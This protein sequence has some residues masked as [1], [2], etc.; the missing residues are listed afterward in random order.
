MIVYDRESFITLRNNNYPIDDSTRKII[1]TLVVKPCYIN[2]YV[3]HN[4]YSGKRSGSKYFNPKYSNPNNSN[5]WKTQLPKHKS[6][7]IGTPVK[8]QTDKIK[9]NIN[10]LLNKLSKNNLDTISHQV[11]EKI[12]ELDEEIITYI[13]E[14]IL[15]KA[16]V[17]PIYCPYYV[18]I[19]LD[20]IKYNIIFKDTIKQIC[21]HYFTMITYYKEKLKENIQ[22]DNYDN[23]CMILKNKSKKKGFSQLIGELYMNNIIDI[24][25]IHRITTILLCNIKTL[26]DNNKNDEKDL[27]ENNILCLIELLKTIQSKTVELENI[28]SYLEDIKFFSKND[29]II[30]RL[31]FKMMDLID[32]YQDR[33]HG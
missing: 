9:K 20:L 15:E 26:L 27:I 22:D 1:A 4:K 12:S 6:I 11:I 32:E 18:K 7:V 13:V 10:G 8:T 29:K 16:I 30:K 21:N 25:A 19:Y 2:K 28:D 33:T 5:G 17:Q 24:D 23:Y 14:C 3:K 31:K